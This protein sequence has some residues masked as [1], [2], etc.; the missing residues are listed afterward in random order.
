ML[1]PDCLK[2]F[3]GFDLLCPL[4]TNIQALIFLAG[5]GHCKEGVVVGKKLFK[6]LLLFLTLQISCTHDFHHNSFILSQNVNSFS[7]ICNR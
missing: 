3:L 4:K 6:N 2:L 1:V 5:S 7:L